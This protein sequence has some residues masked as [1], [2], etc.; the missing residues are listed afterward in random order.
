MYDCMYR[1]NVSAT[2]FLLDTCL[3]DSKV[4][5]QKQ[6]I[7]WSLGLS[8]SMDDLTIVDTCEFCCPLSE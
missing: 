7:I 2:T 6:C 8:I 4:T 1:C 5:W 3:G